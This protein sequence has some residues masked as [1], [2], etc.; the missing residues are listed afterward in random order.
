MPA[1]NATANALTAAECREANRPRDAVCPTLQVEN[2]TAQIGANKLSPLGVHPISPRRVR[3]GVRPHVHEG[4]IDGVGG[5]GGAGRV[6]AVV[7]GK[8]VDEFFVGGRWRPAVHEEAAASAAGGTAALAQ[9]LRG[10][11]GG[12]G[13][14]VAALGDEKQEPAGG[15]KAG[16]HHG[17]VP[18][19]WT[20]DHLAELDLILPTCSACALPELSQNEAARVTYVRVRT[21]ARSRRCKWAGTVY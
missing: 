12:H 10:C 8:A 16:R 3:R 20:V 19:V 4:P 5:V 6:G 7:R 15:E 18:E 9:P 14:R 11:R 1:R 13:R 2:R 21:R 17:I